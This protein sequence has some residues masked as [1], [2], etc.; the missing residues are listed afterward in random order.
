MILFKCFQG[1]VYT[2]TDVSD[3]HEWMKK[4][5]IEHPLFEE[6]PKVEQVRSLRMSVNFIFKLEISLYIFIHIAE[7]FKKIIKHCLC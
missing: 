2:I 3:L 7:A 4:H 5:F 1:I 6:V